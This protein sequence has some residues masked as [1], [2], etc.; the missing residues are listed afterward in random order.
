[1]VAH[2]EEAKGRGIRVRAVVNSQSWAASRSRGRLGAGLGGTQLRRVMKTS[3]EAQ[4]VGRAKKGVT[5]R[6]GCRNKK[7]AGIRPGD[8][9]LTI[10]LV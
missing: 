7:V 1:M 9:K 4:Q 8:V 5:S 6:W 3:W 2:S 10:S